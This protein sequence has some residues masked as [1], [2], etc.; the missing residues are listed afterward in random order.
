MTQSPLHDSK[1]EDGFLK[2]RC[3]IRLY[4]ANTAIN[5]AQ[6]EPENGILATLKLR[7]GFRASA[8]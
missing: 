1:P 8:H 7:Q 5:P 2:Q 3:Q 6:L 4:A